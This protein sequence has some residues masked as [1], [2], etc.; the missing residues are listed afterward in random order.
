[1]NGNQEDTIMEYQY[2]IMTLIKG[3]F[4]SKIFHSFQILTTADIKMTF[5]PCQ[6]YY[7]DSIHGGGTYLL[8]QVR[9]SLTLNFVD[10]W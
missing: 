7:M 1:M 9:D 4:M 8:Y 2:T 3:E 10:Q 5:D 6:N